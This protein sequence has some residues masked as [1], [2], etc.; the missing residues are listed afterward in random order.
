M[1]TEPIE[2]TPYTITEVRT[3]KYFNVEISSVELFTKVSVR[4]LLLD[5]NKQM[6]GFKDL[7]LSGQE[8]LDWKDDSYIIDKVKQFLASQ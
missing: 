3:V 6:I 4:I 1:N 7:V 8:Y 5:E 2:I